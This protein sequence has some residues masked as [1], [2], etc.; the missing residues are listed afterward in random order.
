MVFSRFE[1]H[2]VTE[3]AGRHFLLRVEANVSPDESHGMDGGGCTEGACERRLR[4][5]FGRLPPGAHLIVHGE[6][7]GQ[8]R[9]RGGAERVHL[10]LIHI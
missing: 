6:A 9:G 1:F 7:A 5:A 10:S 4:V 8:V 2:A 3:G